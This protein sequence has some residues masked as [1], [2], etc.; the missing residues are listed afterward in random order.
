MSEDVLRRIFSEGF[1]DYLEEHSLKDVEA[2]NIFELLDTRTFFN[3]LG[4]SYPT[5]SD[6]STVILNR[7]TDS[8]LIDQVGN[9]FHI[10]RITALLLANRLSSFPDIYRKAPRVIVYNANSKTNVRIDQL[11]QLGYAVGFQKLI[12]FIMQ[13]LPQNEIYPS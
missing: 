5:H 7:L 12:D 3:L 11:G 4:I 2:E 13:Q 6:A 9:V 8:R 1:P 10:R